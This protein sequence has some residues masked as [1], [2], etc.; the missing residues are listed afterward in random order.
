[1]EIRPSL[2]VPTMVRAMTETVLP[3]IDPE[4]KLAVEQARLVVGILQLLSKRLPLL[5]RYDRIELRDY[6]TLA[7]R[8]VGSSRGDA[9][10]ARASVDVTGSMERAQRVLDNPASDADA[11]EREL[12][13]LRED[14]S[15]LVR[16]VHQ[17][18]EA[19]S[20]AAVRRAVVEASRA[21]TD[22]ARAWVLP[23]GWEADPSAV[24]PIEAL[25]SEERGR[26]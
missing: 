22:R 5:G 13:A 26:E 3:A 17:D 16:A 15:R 24:R 8:L 18:G 12:L 20:R 14:M 21:E 9:T 23:Q 10:T 2:M 25:L 7:N 1:M 11:I 19:S 6:V 4:N